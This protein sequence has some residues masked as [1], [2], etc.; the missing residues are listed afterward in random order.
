MRLASDPFN[1]GV[2][3][4]IRLCLRTSALQRKAALTGGVLAA[5]L[6]MRRYDCPSRR[7]CSRASRLSPLM[8]E[9]G[10]A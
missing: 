5:C 1:I 8:H 4:V 10:V 9:P 3:S 6:A 7:P 2:W